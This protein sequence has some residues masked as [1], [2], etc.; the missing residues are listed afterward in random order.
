MV[1]ALEPHELGLACAGCGVLH[2]V[3]DGVPIVLSDVDKWLRSESVTLLART[4]LPPALMQRLT[5]TAP[6][7]LQR[8]ARLMASYAPP[9]PSPLLSA[10]REQLGSLSGPILDMG[11]GCTP[12]GV[13]ER[14]GLDLNF[15]LARA[16]DGPAV[17]ADAQDPPFLAQSFAGVMLVNLLDSCANPGLVLAQAE[18]LL[19]PGGRLIVSCAYAWQDSITQ[20]QRRFSPEHLLAA[21]DGQR[22]HLTEPLALRLV[23]AWDPV[24][25]KLRAGPRSVHLHHCQL[26]VAER[27]R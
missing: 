6:E 7:P 9:L 20:V 12:W 2:P 17:V 22:T 26:L 19:A 11:S 16:Y 25:W 13:G 21:V 10:V 8:N 24:L 27:S 5:A 1:A 4:D 15:A 14:T 23:D 3:V 18:A